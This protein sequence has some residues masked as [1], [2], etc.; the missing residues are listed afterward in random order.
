MIEELAPHVFMVGDGLRVVV[1]EQPA[2][3]RVAVGL[4]VGVGSRHESADD[5]GITHFLEHMLYRGTA[6]HPSAHLQNR[7]FEAL[8]GNFGATTHADHTHLAVAVPA[9]SL[10]PTLELLAELCTAPRLGELE[11]ERGIVREEIL[12]HLDEQ[13]RWTDPDDVVRM[14]MFGDHPLGFPITGPLAALD[15]F[16]ETRLRAHLARHYVASNCVLSIAGR[17][18]AS[19]VERLAAR[20][21]GR[22]PGGRGQVPVPFAPSAAAR[23]RKHVASPG[24]QTELRI[25]FLT[26]GDRD[27]IAPALELLMRII[28][29]GMSTRLYHRLVDAG[30]MVYSCWAS[31]EPFSDC[32]ALDIG[33]D[34]QPARLS[35]VCRAIFAMIDELCADGPTPAELEKARQRHRWAVEASLDLAEELEVVMG[36]AIMFDRPRSTR[37]QA[38]RFD[39]LRPDDLREAARLVFDRSRLHVTTVG[40]MTNEARDALRAARG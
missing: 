33:A 11:V 37:A 19:E 7:A 5:N 36:G 4:L 15:G 23:F 40:T 18:T 25:S 38:A 39:G 2:L 17:C 13:G 21:L 24:S 6:R 31:W 1:T 3:H 8:G 9:A 26:P 16:D 30:G 27:P 29:D 32:G 22:L 12:E 34:V 35:E 28:D 14:V 10:A 20:T